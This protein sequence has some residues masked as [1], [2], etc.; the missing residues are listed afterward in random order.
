MCVCV[1]V[2]VCACVCV[3][4]CVGVCVRAYVCT[5]MCVCMCACVRVYVC[6]GGGHVC[7]RDVTRHTSIFFLY[8]TC[9][10]YCYTLRIHNHDAMFTVF[11]P[12][13]YMISVHFVLRNWQVASIVSVT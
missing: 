10:Y 7:V 11:P 4:V 5:Y 8:L 1:C 3:C 9:A 2:C 6:M 13:S 12:S